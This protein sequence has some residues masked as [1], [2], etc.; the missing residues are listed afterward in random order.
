MAIDT[1]FNS[2]NLFETGY[3]LIGG[4]RF[5]VE[6]ISVNRSRDLNPY[7]VASQR[8]PIDQRPG[9]TKIDFSCKRA[10][11]DM[12]FAKM[13]D[14][15][16]TFSM[17]LVNNDVNETNSVSSAGQEICKLTG[18]RFSQDNIGPI[19]GSDVVT[20]D[21]QGSATGIE[22]VICKPDS[23]K[24]KQCDLSCPKN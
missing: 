3:I 9:K 10:F 23:A 2:L 1:T 19:N 14:K 16:C 12:I 15:C 21:L 4:Q 8:D 5:D 11:S 20:E 22:W 13:F 18:C 24:N 6:E 17:I 7:H